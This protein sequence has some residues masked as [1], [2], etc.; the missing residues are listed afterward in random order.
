MAPRVNYNWLAPGYQP[1]TTEFD[2]VESM[3]H[4]D[5][6]QA[7]VQHLEEHGKVHLLLISRIWA[8]YSKSTYI[9]KPG[10]RVH[11]PKLFPG[12]PYEYNEYQDMRNNRG[13]SLSPLVVALGKL[14]RSLTC[15]EVQLQHVLNQG[16]VQE[17][18]DEGEHTR[19]VI[20]EQG[21]EFKQRFD[22]LEQKVD[23]LLN[24]TGD[25][26]EQIAALKCKKA[27]QLKRKKAEE[28]KRKRAEE[29]WFL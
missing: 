3:M 24:P 16:V 23:A 19:A 9:P 10:K 15:Q 25:I 13:V 8:H 5:S 4:F 7:L 27:E 1:P 22:R 12:T 2:E 21:D 17:L 20:Q 18:Q 28:L 11:H 14:R 26:D 29:N 6:D